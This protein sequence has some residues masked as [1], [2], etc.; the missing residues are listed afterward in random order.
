MEEIPYV[1][2][3]RS[4]STVFYSIQILDQFVRGEKRCHKKWHTSDL[5]WFRTT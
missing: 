5:L 4:H 1:L 2:A 3:A